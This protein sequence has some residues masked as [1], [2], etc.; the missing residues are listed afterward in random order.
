MSTAGFGQVGIEANAHKLSPPRLVALDWEITRL[1]RGQLLFSDFRGLQLFWS[2]GYVRDS[3][4]FEAPATPTSGVSSGFSDGA[5]NVHFWVS[6]VP[7]FPIG[8]KPKCCPKKTKTQVCGV[9]GAVS[10]VRLISSL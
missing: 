9:T 2:H 8:P 1:Q 10:R 7:Y 5:L 6:R 3:D 4:A